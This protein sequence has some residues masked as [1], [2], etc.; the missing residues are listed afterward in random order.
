MR[1]PVRRMLAVMMMGLP[2]VPPLDAMEDGE[3]LSLLD[4]DANDPDLEDLRKEFRPRLKQQFQSWADTGI[5]LKE[6][7]SEGLI[8][9]YKEVVKSMPFL[10]ATDMVEELV[11]R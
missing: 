6:A 2:I 9:V 10:R 7:G 5:K 3:M 1:V 4:I 11:G 8:K